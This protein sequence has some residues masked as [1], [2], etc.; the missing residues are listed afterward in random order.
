M[1]VQDYNQSNIWR[2]LVTFQF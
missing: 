2:S 1:L